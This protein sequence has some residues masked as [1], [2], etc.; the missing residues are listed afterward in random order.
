MASW[1]SAVSVAAALIV[2]GALEAQSGPRHSG[3]W[4]G[5][6]AGAGSARVTCATCVEERLGGPSGYLRLGG[7]ISPSVLLGGEGSIWVKTDEDQ[8]QLL[9]SVNAIA[10]L[11]PRLT[12]GFHVKG[13]LGVLRYQVNEDQNPDAT[14]KVSGLSLVLGVG[15][16]LKVASQY[17][18]SPFASLVVSSFGTLSQDDEDLASGVNTS[19]F[20]FGLGITS[21]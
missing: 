10:L 5:V 11:Y 9:G 13:G 1:I 18:L 4:L 2:P 19:L 17:S 16:D 21:H 12:S 8:D 20:Q 15:Y 3:M 14:A 7:T 6:G